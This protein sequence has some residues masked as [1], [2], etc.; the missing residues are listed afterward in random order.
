ML[1]EWEILTVLVFAWR[2]PVMQV[3][4]LAGGG[5]NL[6]LT[7]ENF[8]SNMTLDLLKHLHPLETSGYED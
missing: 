8:V 6:V 1:R 3:T 4:E 7:K 5:G 2:L